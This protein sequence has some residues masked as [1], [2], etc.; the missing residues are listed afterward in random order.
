[1]ENVRRAL[2]RPRTPLRLRNAP[3]ED[4]DPCAARYS[5]FARSSGRPDESQDHH[6]GP[7]RRASAAR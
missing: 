7:R 6:F 1:M 2:R 4:F 5:A 3:G